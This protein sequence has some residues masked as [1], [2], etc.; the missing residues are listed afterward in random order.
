MKKNNDLWIVIGIVAIIIFA[1]N[2]K[3]ITD[4]FAGGG[5]GDYTSNDYPAPPGLVADSANSRYS[6]EYNIKD[7]GILKQDCSVATGNP[8]FIQGTR[9]YALNFNSSN[10]DLIKCGANSALTIKKDES[11]SV[12]FWI[13]PKDN[14]GSS[15]VIGRNVGNNGWKVDYLPASG[16]GTLMMNINGYGTG[17]QV[18]KNQWTHIVFIVNR[19]TLLLDTYINGVKQTVMN[20]STMNSEMSRTNIDCLDAELQIGKV[21]GDTTLYFNGT[22]DEFMIFKRVLTDAEVLELYGEPGGNVQC[23]LYQECLG[24]LTGDKIVNTADSSILTSQWLK[25]CNDANQHCLGADLS[26][27]GVVNYLDQDILSQNWLKDCNPKPVPCPVYPS[28][29]GDMNGDN[30]VNDADKATYQTWFVKSCNDAN[31]HCEGADLDCDGIV[32]MMDFSILSEHWLI[33]CNP[34]S[35]SSGGGGGGGGGGGSSTSPKINNTQIT[36]TEPVST[37]LGNYLPIILLIIGGYI[38]YKYN[39]K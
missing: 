36:T 33:N 28:C 31:N 14:L 22:L 17:R 39:K 15:A 19:Q 20:P 10:N 24:D 6:F 16:S 26:C 8:K 9:N 23:P 25:T 29:I 38:L 12:A 21:T 13:N 3:P 37:N 35:S 1:M 30:I 32:N 34:S 7:T 11:F 27:D 2:F 18:S 4:I 5:S